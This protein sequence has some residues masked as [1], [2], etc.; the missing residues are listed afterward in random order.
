[1]CMDFLVSALSRE[2]ALPQSK[3][4]FH[5]ESGFLLSRQGSF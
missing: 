5:L 2:S 1:M 3:L 4:I